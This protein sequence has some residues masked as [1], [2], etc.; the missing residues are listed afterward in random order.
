MIEFII[1]FILEFTVGWGV[2]VANDCKLPR[3]VRIGWLFFVTLV[4]IALTG[5]FVWLVITLDNLFGKI[6]S[7]AVVF[8]F[9]GM[10]IYF[11]RKVIK[12]KEIS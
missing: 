6:I 7:A 10:L 8:F 5:F 9:V 3:K 12:A 1:E 2:E 4:Y 11:W